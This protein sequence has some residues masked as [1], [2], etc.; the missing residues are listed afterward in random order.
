MRKRLACAK[1]EKSNL[2]PQDSEGSKSMYN[3]HMIR[4]MVNGIRGEEE[5]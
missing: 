1:R 2:H 3:S 5:K 4:K